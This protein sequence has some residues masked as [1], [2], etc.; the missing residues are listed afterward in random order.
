MPAMSR[1]ESLLCRSAPWRGFATCVVLPWALDRSSIEGNAL[2]IG[3]GSGAM[4]EALL[5][6]Y[7]ALRL[8]ATD[9]DPLMVS[10]AE[11][12]L[13]SYGE[14]VS[15]AQADATT[16]PFNDGAFDVAL[17]F[18]ML[19][20]V[21]RWEEALAEL[22]RVVRPGGQVLGCDVIKGRFFDWS[23]RTFG[24]GDERLLALDQFKKATEALPVRIDRIDTRRP[25]AFRFA[26]TRV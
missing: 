14:R 6:R 18:L 22:V 15:V 16:L 21:G 7:P 13:K 3:S 20:H 2:E 5:R 4:A 19:H 1:V 9:F 11:K 25:L 10:A 8:T 12:R 26:L 17:T 24:S 23:E